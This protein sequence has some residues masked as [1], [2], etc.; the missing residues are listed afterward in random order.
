MAADLHAQFRAIAQQCALRR[1]SAEETAA[2]LALCPYAFA[3]RF[4][5]REQPA[6]GGGGRVLTAPH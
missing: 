3:R 4:P 5:R 1:L 2:L 6:R